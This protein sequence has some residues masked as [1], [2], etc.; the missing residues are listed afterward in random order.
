[1]KF[2]LDCY[3]NCFNTKFHSKLMY[4]SNCFNIADSIFKKIDNLSNQVLRSALNINKFI[5]NYIFKISKLSHFYTPNIKFKFINNFCNNIL[6]N[7]NNT[8]LKIKNSTEE[9]LDL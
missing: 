5:P 4:Q 1:M 8:N 6:N 3:L 2:R 7:L 9:I